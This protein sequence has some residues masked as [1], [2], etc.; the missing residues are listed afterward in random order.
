MGVLQLHGA[1]A[2]AS[3]CRVA[4]AR[5]RQLPLRSLPGPLPP[6]P[7]FPPQRAAPQLAD[8]PISN[9]GTLTRCSKL[10]SRRVVLLG[11]AAHSV[12]PA[13]GQGANSALEGAVTLAAALQGGWGLC[14]C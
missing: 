9:G 14:H 4:L 10:N 1:V 2:C 6:S 3:L 5:P 7:R 8:S 13:L 11:D 12:Y